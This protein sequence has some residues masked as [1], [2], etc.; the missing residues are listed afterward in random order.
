MLNLMKMV[1]SD[2][3]QRLPV[4]NPKNSD[5]N[6]KTN[7]FLGWKS[8]KKNLCLI[9]PILSDYECLGFLPL[10]LYKK[11]SSLQLGTY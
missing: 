3:T 11:N 7:W 2:P 8:K 5:N 6:L 1:R 10:E 4:S 9:N